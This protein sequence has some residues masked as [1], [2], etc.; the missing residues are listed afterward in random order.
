MRRKLERKV[1]PREAQM[2][3]ASAHYG[4]QFAK[5][6]R[7]AEIKA[8]RKY[9]LARESRRKTPRRGLLAKVVTAAT[10]TAARIMASPQ[11]SD[12]RPIRGA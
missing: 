6:Y 11:P 1:R 10:S 8:A 12:K 9:R 3:P 5:Q 2:F 4:V 7:A